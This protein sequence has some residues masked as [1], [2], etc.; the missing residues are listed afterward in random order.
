MLS[1][2]TGHNRVP[3]PPHMITGIKKRLPIDRFSVFSAGG[4]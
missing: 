3:A 1:R 2:E 4:Y